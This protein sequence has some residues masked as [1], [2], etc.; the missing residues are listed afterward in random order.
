MNKLYKFAERSLLWGI[1]LIV[2]YLII[3]F[4]IAFK[5]IGPE[6][7]VAILLWNLSRF[8]ILIWI[9]GGMFLWGLLSS[10]M[11]ARYGI[12]G[13]R[14]ISVKMVLD[15]LDENSVFYQAGLRNR[16]EVVKLDG[17]P[18]EDND[19]LDCWWQ[20]RDSITLTILRNNQEVQVTLRKE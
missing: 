12:P 13:S 11:S 3:F 18:L 8:A 7:Q 4:V 19:F 16:D 17:E 6:S 9:F 2:L 20:H 14:V 10:K 15:N 5:L 1:P